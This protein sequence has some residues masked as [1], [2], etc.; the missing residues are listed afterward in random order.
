MRLASLVALSLFLVVTIAAFPA[1]A[2]NRRPPGNN[3]QQQR[4]PARGAGTIK[5]PAGAGMEVQTDGGDR[6]LVQV[7]Q[8]SQQIEYLGSAE[9]SW[10]HPGLI[11]RFTAIVDKRGKIQEPI[12][13]IDAITMRDGYVLGVVID[14]PTNNNDGAGLFQDPKPEKPA[15]KPTVP[16]NVPATIIGRL[17]E[18]KNG[19]FQVQIPGKM[20]KGELAEGAKISIDYGNLSLVKPGDKIDFQGWSPAGMK[21]LVYANRVTVTAT[22]KLVGETKK[23][24]KPAEKPDD[25]KLD[26]KVEKPAAEKPAAKPAE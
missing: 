13:Q 25:K 11:V 5:G 14:N 6:Y 7:E 10:L 22:E 20:I 17:T 24:G 4:E 19:K 1:A 15:K 8:Q 16:D 26:E 12:S 3:P 2:Q 23:R 9:H 18:F 21:Q